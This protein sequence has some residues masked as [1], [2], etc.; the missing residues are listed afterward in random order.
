ML[1]IAFASRGEAACERKPAAL[2]ARLPTAIV[3]LVIT[4][5]SRLGIAVPTRSPRSAAS[6]H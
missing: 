2:L 4:G 5:S 1:R 6:S 3:L